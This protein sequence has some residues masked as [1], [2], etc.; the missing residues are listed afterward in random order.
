MDT[1]IVVQAAQYSNYLNQG[2][3]LGL[4]G[5]ASPTGQP[6][7]N[8]FPTRDG[9]IQVTALRQPQVE[10][11]FTLIRQKDAFEKTEF[12]TPGA[13]VKNTPR[14]FDLLSGALEKNTTAHWMQRLAAAGIPVA[15]IRELP[16]VV[17]DPQFEYRGVFETIPSPMN[18]D[19]TV[20]LVKAGYI[21]DRDG[22]E[23]RNGPPALG[24]HTRE[25]LASLGYDAA[26][27]ATFEANGVI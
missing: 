25:V 16:E 1:A 26:T 17:R 18:A 20:T 5:N 23:V 8:V 12:N 14:V 7:A 3:L 2:N 9:F 22:P 10:K 19:E 6:T 13:R 27:I 15:E 11:L 24:E 4:L 21:T